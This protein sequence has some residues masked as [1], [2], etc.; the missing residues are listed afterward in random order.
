[1]S[2]VYRSDRDTN[3]VGSKGN[4]DLGPG[5]YLA[6]IEERNSPELKIPFNSNTFRSINNQKADI[7]GPGSYFQS[8]DDSNMIYGSRKNK[9]TDPIYKTFEY[10]QI[11][12]IEP[13]GIVLKEDLK[14]R[15]GFLSRERRFK[16]G[17]PPDETTPGPGYYT[18][19]NH[20]LKPKKAHPVKS[21]SIAKASGKM[22]IPSIPD[23]N[24]QGGYDYVQD[25]EGLKFI[26]L[27]EEVE[28]K[29]TIGPGAYDLNKDTYWQKKGTA[30]SKLQAPKEA[31]FAKIQETNETVQEFEDAEDF[32]KRK[33]KALK[34][35][36]AYYRSN[37]ERRKKIVGLFKKQEEID[38][39]A[40]IAKDTPGPGYYYMNNENNGFR[41]KRVKE[42]MQILGSTEK[43]FP[44]PKIN[45][46]V[47]PT[48]YFKEQRKSLNL[49][50]KQQKFKQPIKVF[51][52][53]RESVSAGVSTV[54]SD[55]PGPGS[56]DPAPQGK[57]AYKLNKKVIFG[58]SEKRFVKPDE[59]KKEENPGPGSYLKQQNWRRHNTSYRKRMIKPERYPM[60]LLAKEI[61]KEEDL[62]PPVGTYN[63][64][65]MFDIK[66]K[67]E[68][69][70]N[71]FSMVK[72]PFDSL[73]KRF[74]PL[75][76]EDNLGPGYYH[77]EKIFKKS[78]PLVPFG[79]ESN[80]FSEQK[81]SAIGPGM[82]NHGSYFD[83]N[84]KTY[85]VL[86]L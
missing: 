56:Y 11:G 13:W 78:Q 32:I 67:V 28:N 15:K 7:P 18:P 51:K 74:E 37:Q 1:M 4:T 3:L 50:L 25:E 27:N 26:A 12:S 40:S 80:R 77:K 5:Q 47:G 41:V 54:F 38:P 43:R 76:A 2:F 61:E 82:Y 8:K 19:A 55:T 79:A 83:W 64:N 71:K 23:R 39:L 81:D 59:K 44:E 24:R 30:W 9:S 68:K 85:N 69:K 65:L 45:S 53:E 46:T 52:D 20:V 86:Y 34:D 22:A 42:S 63:P 58:S 84:K 35:M 48:S 33:E 21:R 60:E 29:N 49:E 6:A 73:V 16:V 31:L 10:E 57:P 75:K 17:L 66:G 36:Q 72:A 62:I 14:E 70:V